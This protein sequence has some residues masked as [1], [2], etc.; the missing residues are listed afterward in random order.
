MKNKTIC[1][2]FDGVIH[3]YSKGWHDG[4]IYD[5]PVEGTAEFIN[6]LRD[7][8]WEIIIYSTRSN[9][10]VNKDAAHQVREMHMWMQNNGIYF[11]EISMFKP[12]AQIYL[13]DRAIR[14][15]NWNKAYERITK[16]TSK[17]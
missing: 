12:H 8:G 10:V 2:D 7:D 6:N 11:D 1:I 9:P 13:D 5:E 15:T 14:F 4:S 16:H 17:S 3:K